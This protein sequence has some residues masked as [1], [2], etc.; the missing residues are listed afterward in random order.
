M[1]EAVPNG[2]PRGA[3]VVCHGGSGLAP[4]ERE[5]VER[6]AALGF[7]AVAPDLYG[8]PPSVE[9]IKALVTEPTELRRRVLSVVDQMRVHGKV[10]VIGHC[11]GGTAALE[12]AR[13]GADLACAVAFHGGL[14]A[15]VAATAIRARVLACCGAADPFCPRE[16]RAGFEDEM[17]KAGASWQLHVYGGALHGFTVR[18]VERPGCAY[19]ELADRASWAAMTALLDETI[20]P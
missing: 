18:G 13:S 12:A 8:A 15:P 14:A 10:A 9:L 7:A 19:D 3:V 17:T 11:F 6:L 20:G 5:V 4:H 2:S 16:Q 1:I